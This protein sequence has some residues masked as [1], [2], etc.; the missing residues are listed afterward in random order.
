ML[1]TT[2]DAPALQVRSEELDLG[3]IDGLLLLPITIEHTIDERSPLCGLTHASLQVVM[4]GHAS[5]RCLRACAPQLFDV[6]RCAAID[7]EHHFPFPSQSL[8]AEV[9]VTF[10]GTTEMGASVAPLLGGVQRAA[11]LAPA[12]GCQLCQYP[13]QAT[14]SCR[15]SRTCRPRSGGATS[16]CAASTAHTM[17]TRTT[18]W[19]PPSEPCT[20]QLQAARRSFC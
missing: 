6:I 4:S 8:N 18:G 5:G 1:V 2:P 3:N 17:M 7:S 20:H 10:E 16:S 19:T 15:G 11:L 9:V 12:A 14:P 13:V